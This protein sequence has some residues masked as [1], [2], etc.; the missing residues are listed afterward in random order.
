MSSFVFTI[1]N[2]CLNQ[3]P[4]CPC[5]GTDSNRCPQSEVNN[6]LPLRLWDVRVHAG[7]GL[8][9]GL[10]PPHLQPQQHRRGSCRGAS[11]HQEEEQ[12]ETDLVRNQITEQ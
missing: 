10:L 9:R 12:G 7:A 2:K 5:L 11:R 3:K 1:K 8:L 4:F 6:A